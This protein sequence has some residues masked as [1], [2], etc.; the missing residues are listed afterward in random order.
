MNILCAWV[1]NLGK[2][3]GFF[4]RG[5]NFFLQFDGIVFFGCYF[6]PERQSDGYVQRI[7]MIDPL[8]AGRWRVYVE[9]EE[10]PCNSAWFDRPQSNVLV[11]RITGSKK[12]KML[13][14]L[15]VLILVCRCR[16][17][18]F[19]SVMRMHNN[20]FGILLHIPFIHKAVDVHGVVPEE[21]R[22]CSDYLIAERYEKQEKLAVEKAGILI[23]VTHAMQQY[24]Q[25]K[26]INKMK[27]KI[28]SCP[29][30]PSFTPMIATR[31]LVDGKTVVVYAGGL[32]K[33][34]LVAKMLDAIIR[35]KDSCI[36]CFY[37]PNPE[38]V[39]NMLPPSV[40]AEVTLESKTQAELMLCY[41]KCHYGFILREDNVVNWVACPTKL[42]EYLAMGI[43][44]IMD[45]E[46]IGDFKLLGMCFISLEDFLVG[47]LP[48]EERRAKMALE[49]FRIYEQLKNLMLTGA[50]EIK[51][52]FTPVDLRNIRE[53]KN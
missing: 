37:C 8:F 9:N 49:N 45:S 19:H 53:V 31:P 12:R 40:T 42:I 41:S 13:I 38:V 16:K 34:Q 51:E 46:N 24:L 3:L 39:K 35:T 23:V 11:L 33:W 44:P 4:V 6:Y 5:I 7:K 1:A 20:R 26:Y 17:I 36:H 10:L 30:F 15:V 52:F 25:S 28:I 21:F 22:L 29:M 14:R 48:D 50:N 27:A 32:Q 47:R 43:V 2:L 18:Y